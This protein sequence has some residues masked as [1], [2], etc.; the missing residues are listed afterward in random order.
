MIDTIVLTGIEVFATHG[1]LAEEKSNPQLFR[2]D[3]SIDL[4]LSVPAETDDVG[5]T[6]DYGQLAQEVHDL[7]RDHQFSLLEKLAS[8]IADLVGR[9]PRV[10]GVSVT[11]HKPEAPIAVPVSDVAVT[12]RR[13]R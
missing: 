7:V 5:D 10:A 3:L 12:I 4:D 6:L 8:A 13:G 2:V 1:V 9:D 11:V